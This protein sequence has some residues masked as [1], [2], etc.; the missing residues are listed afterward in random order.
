MEEVNTS[1]SLNN[2]LSDNNYSTNS[3]SN[4]INEFCGKKSEL[5][6]TGWNEYREVI[7]GYQSTIQNINNNA[8]SFQSTLSSLSQEVNNCLNGYTGNI[9][10]PETINNFNSEISNIES[11]ITACKNRIT[12]LEGELIKT[13]RIPVL[14]LEEIISWK[15]VTY[16]DQSVKAKIQN[17]QDKLDNLKKY[18]DL[19]N[20][21]YKIKTKYEGAFEELLATFKSINKNL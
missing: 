16:E 18:Q 5:T 1:N 21:L 11:E 14:N 8:S 13:K 15:T 6:G 4:T 9:R 10:V 12:A 19:I 3:L 2:S 20:T 7:E 17:E